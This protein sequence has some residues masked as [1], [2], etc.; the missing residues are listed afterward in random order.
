[1]PMFFLAYLIILL[2]ACL[3]GIATDVLSFH[4][5]VETST[6]VYAIVFSLLVSA[7]ATVR[8]RSRRRRADG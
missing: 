7:T 5:G 8:E 3:V 2:V 1:M 6:V 4:D